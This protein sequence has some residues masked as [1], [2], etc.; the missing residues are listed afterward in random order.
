MESVTR[1]R[2]ST[3]STSAVRMLHDSG[4][5]SSGMGSRRVLTSVLVFVLAGVEGSMVISGK[6]EGGGRVADGEVGCNRGVLTVEFMALGLT[7]RFARK[8]VKNAVVAAD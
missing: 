6:G 1:L 3:L 7:L 5:R 2:A 8:K 4:G